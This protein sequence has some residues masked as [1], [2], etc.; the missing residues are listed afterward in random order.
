MLGLKPRVILFYGP[1]GV[2]KS[3]L[4]CSVAEAEYRAKE[5]KSV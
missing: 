3:T 5:K 4:A 2:G 1:Q